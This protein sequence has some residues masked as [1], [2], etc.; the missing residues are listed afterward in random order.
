MV[1]NAACKL[2]RGERATTECS[3]AKCFESD[4]AVA[5]TA[6]AMQ[7]FGGSG[8]IRGMLVERLYRDAKIT[9][10]CEGTSEIQRLI[11]ACG[12]LQ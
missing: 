6:Q 8:F 2:G 12:L 3:M 11:I 4:A 5:H 7:V 10:I 9:Q 1:H